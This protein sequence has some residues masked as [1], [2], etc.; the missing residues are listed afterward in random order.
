MFKY[1]FFARSFEYQSIVNFAA[2]GLDDSISGKVAPSSIS[3]AMKVMRIRSQLV[4]RF[5]I[6]FS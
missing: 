1:D 4:L 3:Q 6:V 2:S 5:T